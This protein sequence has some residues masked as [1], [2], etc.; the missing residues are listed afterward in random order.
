MCDEL[1]F[2]DILGRHPRSLPD[3]GR[4][5]QG[6]LGREVLRISAD[7]AARIRNDFWI[8]TWTVPASE[9]PE[10]SAD[11][12]LTTD[13]VPPCRIDRNG[14]I[15]AVLDKAPG[16]SVPNR[17]LRFFSQMITLDGA[18]SRLYRHRSLQMNSRFSA[19]SFFGIY[20]IVTPLHRSRD[21]KS[22][23]NFVKLVHFVFL[24][25]CKNN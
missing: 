2:V 24:F 12:H 5:A 25:F 14:V 17:K 7:S 23:Q 15:P 6:D 8:Q 16:G 19:S 13:V 3:H 9:C 10:L 1:Q 21:W 18:R 22:R 4:H 11:G 20:K